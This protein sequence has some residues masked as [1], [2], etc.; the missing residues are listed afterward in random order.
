VRTALQLA[1]RIEKLEATAREAATPTLGATIA[2][3]LEG[4]HPVPR[5]SD[6]ELARTRMGRLL[7]QRQRLAGLGY[8]ER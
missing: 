3:I 5:T 1:G 6:E 2:A 4:R 8:P 7:L